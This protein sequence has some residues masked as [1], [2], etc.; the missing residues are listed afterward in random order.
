MRLP[1]NP[2]KRALLAGR[3]QIG[4]WSS[5]ASHVSVEILAGSG[6]DWLL[7]DMEHSPNELPMVHSQL[8]ACA[9]TAA[10]PIVRPPWNDMVTIKRLL[11][12][13][14]QTLL[15]PYVETEDEARD[16]VSFTRYPP[17]GV[18]GYASGARASGFGRIKDYPQ[19]CASELC[20]LVQ[21]ESRLGLQ[22]LERIAAVEGVDGIFIGPGDLA[23]ALGHVGN[24]GHPDV[25]ATVDDTIRRI[26][27]TGKPAGILTGDEALARHY[28]E[29]GCLFT[30]VGSDIGLLARN[31]EQLAARFKTVG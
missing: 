1:E 18:R 28:V 9:G 26:V 19:L 24:I 17:E 7:L 25:Q 14:A 27:A 13:G 22:N 31:A 23:A 12:S 21:I 15:I 10:H 11:D 6:F 16:A 8:Q 29:L 30:A 5:L 20:V 3:Q 4:L 2:F